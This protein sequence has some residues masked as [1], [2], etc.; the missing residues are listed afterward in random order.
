M[1]DFIIQNS[2]LALTVSDTGAEICSLK[3]QM[4]GTEYIWQGDPASWEEHAPLLFPAVGDWKENQYIYKGNVY[5]MPRHGFARTQKFVVKAEGQTLCCTLYDNEETRRI[6]P[7]P[8][9]LE[10]RYSLDRNMVH[11]E[12]Y[13]QNRGEEVMPY[14]LGEHLGFRVPLSDMEQYEDYRVV[15]EKTEQADR[16]PLLDGSVIG[17]P[18]PCLENERQIRLDRQMFASGAWN[19]EGLRSQRVCLENR[20]NRH[21]IQLDFPGFSH[22]SLWGIPEAPFLCLEPCNGIA[23]SKE[24]G[25]DP[26]KKKG[27]CLLQPKQTKAVAFAISVQSEQIDRKLEESLEASWIQRRQSIRKFSGRVVTRET[28]CRILRHAQTSPSAANNREW[29]FLVVQEREAQKKIAGLSPYATPAKEAAFLIILCANTEKIKKDNQGNLWWIQ[30]MGACAQ[31]L[32]LAAKEEHLDG[33]WLGFYPDE[34]RVRALK[35]YLHCK[36]TYLPFAVLAMGY[37]AEAYGKKERY[38]PHCIHFWDRKE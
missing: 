7:F 4:E 9:C 15:F 34:N 31:T 29:E 22:F 16:Y 3:N 10:I 19:F 11:V 21:R 27:I 13:I 30:D 18:V 6:Y 14:S 5:E 28:I 23:A 38:D 36:T 26:Y 12:Q 25:Y 17:D 37:A 32:L 8:F 24:E 33:V 35:E 2:Y 1:S 20:R